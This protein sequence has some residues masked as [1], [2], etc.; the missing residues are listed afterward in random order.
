MKIDYSNNLKKIPPYAF[1]EISRK[2]KEM[3]RKRTQRRKMR[4]NITNKQSHQ[5]N[6]KGPAMNYQQAPL[7]RKDLKNSTWKKKPQVKEEKKRRVK[8]VR[9]KKK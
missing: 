6:I 8:K 3:K 1:A 2:K 7:V 4:T 5:K 9:R